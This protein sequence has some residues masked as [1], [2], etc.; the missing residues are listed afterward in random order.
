[1]AIRIVLFS[2]LIGTPG[3][4]ESSVVTQ[5]SF[6]TADKGELRRIAEWR[7]SNYSSHG[8]YFNTRDS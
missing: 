1:M 5:I 2:W 7:R 6:L 4:V 3:R 8:A